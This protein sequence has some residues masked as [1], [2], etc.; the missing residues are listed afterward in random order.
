LDPTKLTQVFRKS[1]VSKAL[2]PLEA[3]AE[4]EG[5]SQVKQFQYGTYI[6]KQEA[7]IIL[8]SEMSRLFCTNIPDL[9]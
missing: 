4:Q 2:P 5:I 7:I 8:L 3:H 1:G 6:T 9:F